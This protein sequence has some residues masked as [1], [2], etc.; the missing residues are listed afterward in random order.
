MTQVFSEITFGQLDLLLEVS[1]FKFMDS[2]LHPLCLMNIFVKWQNESAKYP[3]MLANW[4]LAKQLVWETTGF[5]QLDVVLTHTP[6]AWIRKKEKSILKYLT[7]ELQNWQEFVSNFAKLSVIFPL[8]CSTLIIITCYFFM[9]HVYF[10]DLNLSLSLQHCTDNSNNNNND[11]Y[12]FLI[13]QKEK[14]IWEI[15]ARKR[16]HSL[17][18]I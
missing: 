8:I 4:S 12:W 18:E 10:P 5:Y 15:F 1:C 3:N 14:L 9:I 11:I 6:H 13:Q 17:S 16:E 7:T 2:V